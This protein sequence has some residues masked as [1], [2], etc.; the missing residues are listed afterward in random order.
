MEAYDPTTGCLTWLNK[1]AEYHNEHLQI[2]L[3][4]I[5]ELHPHVAIIYADYYNAAM[6]L[7]RS[8]SKF[9]FTKGALSACCGA[10]EVPY[11]FNSSAPCGYP[12]SFAFDDPFLYVNWDGPHLTG[13]SLSIDYQK[14]IG[15]TIHHSSY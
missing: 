8:P 3:N 11:H 1:F 5:R 6:N 10:G 9:G 14:F 2:E 4:R 7:Y 15:R 13:G 12:P